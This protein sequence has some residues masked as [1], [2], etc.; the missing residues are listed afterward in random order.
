MNAS[1]VD[2]VVTLYERWGA[3]GYDEQVSQVEH[4]LQTAA[5]AGAAGAGP[6]LVAAALLHDVG[7]LLDLEVSGG[8]PAL[9]EH[10]KGHESTGSHYLSPLFPPSVTGPIALHVRAKRYRC[11]VDEHHQAR[12]SPG[13][14][15][16]LRRQGGPMSVAEAA[17]FERNPG[18]GAAVALREWDDRAKIEGLGV[19]PLS[20]YHELLCRV[21]A[22][23]RRS[24]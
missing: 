23:R 19:A 20:S 18:F 1:S 24:A 2:E 14:R 5:L 9:A 3:D 21:A 7:H 6:E 4:A 22:G 10:D 8:S 17:A 12:L 11:A 13:S 15:R 16:S